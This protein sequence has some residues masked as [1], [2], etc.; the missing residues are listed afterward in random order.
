MG[1]K[2]IVGTANKIVRFEETGDIRGDLFRKLATVL[3]IEDA[4]IQQ[5]IEEDRRKYFAEWTEWANQPVK[6]E[7]V[8]RAI[9]GVFAGHQLPEHLHTAEEMEQY[10]CDFAIKCNKKTWLVL[11]RRLKIYFDENGKKSVQESAPGECNGPEM[12]LKNGRQ[13]F[14]LGVGGG[15]FGITPITEPK[16]H[17]LGE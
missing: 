12:R 15:G 13:S 7:I 16:K 4:T 10:A 14:L 1:Y 2:S 11:S 8:F 6:P 5:L 17:G 3:G 9:P